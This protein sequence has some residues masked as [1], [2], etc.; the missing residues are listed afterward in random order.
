MLV[1]AT[2]VAESASYD[3]VLAACLIA[4]GVGSLVLVP[5]LW[6][7]YATFQRNPPPTGAGSA[8]GAQGASDEQ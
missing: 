2:T 5:S 7:L 8:R 3:S 1:P 4:L 6:L